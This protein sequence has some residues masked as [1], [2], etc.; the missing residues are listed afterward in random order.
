[1]PG[2][3][4]E[5]VIDFDQ[6]LPGKGDIAGF[7]ADLAKDWRS[8][9]GSRV[10][11]TTESD[12]SISATHDGKGHVQ[13]IV[14]LKEYLWTARGTIEVEAGSLDRIAADAKDVFSVSGR[15]DR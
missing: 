3:S 5:A 15:G 4:A 13:R 9:A 7:L 12:F 14:K 11:E 1:L 6:P 2:I 10:F 8:W